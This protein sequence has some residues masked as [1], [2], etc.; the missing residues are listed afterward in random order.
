MAGRGPISRGIG[1][2][3]IHMAVF[4]LPSLVL[5]P[6]SGRGLQNQGNRCAVN[7][8]MQILRR[9]PRA[10]EYAIACKMG[11]S[12]MNKGTGVIDRYLLCRWL[13]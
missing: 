1:K 5:A 6:V 3:W 9:F 7:S 12:E 13:L 10:R 11:Q 2:N 8:I 4:K